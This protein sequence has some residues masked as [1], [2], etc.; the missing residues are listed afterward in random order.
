VWWLNWILLALCGSGI[1]Y[2]DFKT[3]LISVW[4]L[5]IFTVINIIGYLFYSSFSQLI[6]NII[7]CICYFLFSYLIIIFFYFLKTRKFVKI[8][9]AKIGLADIILFIAI[10]FTIEPFAF[11]LFFS[12]SFILS[13]LIQLLFIHR[14][15]QVPLAGIMVLIYV[16]YLLVDKFN[17]LSINIRSI[18]L[19]HS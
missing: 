7:F 13:L 11:I 3:R 1:A 10:G 15:K 2:Q 16:V 4:L 9:N 5:L 8:I 6:E 18:E 19:F 12:A 17:L 14:N